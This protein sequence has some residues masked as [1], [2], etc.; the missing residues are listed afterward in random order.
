MQ[1]KPSTVTLSPVLPSVRTGISKLLVVGRGGGHLQTD[2]GGQGGC[3]KIAAGSVGHLISPLQ[4]FR[5]AKYY[6][7]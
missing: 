1:P 7:I 6:M 5:S 2:S 3:E 4:S